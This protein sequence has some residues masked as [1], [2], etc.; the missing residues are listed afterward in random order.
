MKRSVLAALAL[1]GALLAPV[2][3]P[4]LDLSNMTD[5]EKAA[6][7]AAVRDYLMQHPEVLV[8]AINSLEARQQAQAAQT[9]AALIAQNADAIFRSP[10]DWVG[11]NPD[12]DVTMVEFMDY[13]CGYCKKAYP[14]VAQLLKSD[15]KIRYVVKEFPILGPQSELGAR[16]AVAVRQLA[17]DAAYAKVHE[18]LMTQRGDITPDS[19]KALAKAQGLDADAI[20]KRMGGP[21]VTAVLQANMDLAQT[22]NVS[23]TPGFVIGNGMLRGYAPMA[24][25]QQ[26]VSAARG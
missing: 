26:I 1:S 8:D 13:R 20:T 12:G 9:D 14:D 3:A 22:L 19:L 7:G 10:D 18:A 4:A 2:A 5:S 25:M 11:G 24:Q 23:G 17:G 6:F 16:F 15:G 21:E